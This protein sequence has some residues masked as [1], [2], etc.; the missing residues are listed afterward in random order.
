VGV[1][2]L[3]IASDEEIGSL[4]GGL[5]SWRRGL[6]VNYSSVNGE[7]WVPSVILQEL[8]MPGTR[9]NKVSVTR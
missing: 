2:G 8:V 6:M 4:V 9:R 7:S 5:W 1:V 3:L